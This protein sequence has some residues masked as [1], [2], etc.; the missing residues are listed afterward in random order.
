MREIKEIIGSLQSNIRNKSRKGVQAI[1]STA[2]RLRSRTSSLTGQ[3][4]QK[5]TGSKGRKS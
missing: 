4:R 5:L 1:T 2:A 3:L